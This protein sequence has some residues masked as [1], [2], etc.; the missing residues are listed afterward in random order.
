MQVFSYGTVEDSDYLIKNIHH[1]P[2]CGVSFTFVFNGYAGEVNLPIPG[3]HNAYN[4]AAAIAAVYTAGVRV[5]NAIESLSRYSGTG[6]RFDIQGE[7]QGIT[8][9]DDYAHHPTEIRATLSAARCRYPDQQIWVV[10]QPHTYSRTQQLFEEFKIAFSDADHVIVTEIYASREMKQE[11]SSR[12]VVEEMDHPDVRQIAELGAV[13]DF[14]KQNLQSGDILL[15]L[16][17]GDADQISR[18]LL[19]HYHQLG[20]KNS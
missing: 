14:L 18:D 19:H 13:T 16:S 12:E 6:R 8:I 20:G 4:A 1:T 10:W 2:G 17:A 3:D 7:V 15:V 5:E 9:I 11:Y